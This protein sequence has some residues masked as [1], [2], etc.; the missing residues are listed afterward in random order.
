MSRSASAASNPSGT[1]TSSKH[2]ADWRPDPAPAQQSHFSVDAP[3]SLILE[4]DCAPVSAG[5]LP[6]RNHHKP[7]RAEP[8][9]PA[10]VHPL[11]RFSYAKPHRKVREHE[12]EVLKTQR[13]T[14]VSKRRSEA[15]PLALRDANRPP[16]A[17]TASERRCPSRGSESASQAKSSAAVTGGSSGTGTNRRCVRDPLQPATPPPSLRRLWTAE[18]DLNARH[19]RSL[20]LEQLDGQARQG[21]AET[22]RMWTEERA[23]REHETWLWKV[24]S[25]GGVQRRQTGMGTEKRQGMWTDERARRQ[26]EAELWRQERGAEAQEEAS[27]PAV[28][29]EA[30][31]HVS[32][33]REEGCSTV[34]VTS[35]FTSRGVPHCHRYN[36][37]QPFPEGTLT[38]VGRQPDGSYFSQLS[39]LQQ[40]WAADFANGREWQAE[41]VSIR[42]PQHVDP[43]SFCG[44]PS[45]G[46]RSRYGVPVYHKF[47]YEG[48]SGPAPPQ[49]APPQFRAQTPGANKNRGWRPSGSG[50]IHEQPYDAFRPYAPPPFPARR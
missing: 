34:G 28:A 38:N 30:G 5:A 32:P 37:E 40:Q 9:V 1:S 44:S 46:K 10:A 7:K 22:H 39:Q 12:A 42:G 14:A 43:S 3:A 4:T 19:R 36:Y 41:G 23:R 45:F 26:H 6:L 29:E 35:A 21:E 11:Q 47:Q 49:A 17:E 15:T 13:A 16:T 31:V 8:V 25:P 27:A 24:A 2:R 50:R 20:L 48:S 18:R 33:P